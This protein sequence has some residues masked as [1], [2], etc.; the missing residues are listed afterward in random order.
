MASSSS[1][2][3]K[4]SAKVIRQIRGPVEAGSRTIAL[5][6]TVS[7]TKAPTRLQADVGAATEGPRLHDE[8]LVSV[9]GWIR[10]G[11]AKETLVP[12][13][14]LA[15]E[16]QRYWLLVRAVADI[17]VDVAVTCQDGGN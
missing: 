9:I 1:R 5:L 14:P 16:G 15:L 12:D 6:V 4:A 2:K 3:A 8:D 10:D 13:P 11:D 7:G 17:G